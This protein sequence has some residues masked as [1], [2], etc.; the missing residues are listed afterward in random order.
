[1]NSISPAGSSGRCRDYGSVLTSHAIIK[2][3]TNR[4]TITFGFGPRR[5][6]PHHT[7]RRKAFLVHRT[8]NGYPAS[9]NPGQPPDERDPPDR[10][11]LARHLRC[12]PRRFST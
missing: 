3:L 10:R 4:K 5:H 1:M 11:R 7:E 9:N 6:W 8:W 2:E 12:A